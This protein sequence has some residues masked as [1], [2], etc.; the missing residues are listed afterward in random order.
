MAVRGN[1]GGISDQ[2]IEQPAN[3]ISL[4]PVYPVNMLVKNPNVDIDVSPSGLSTLAAAFK[5]K[6][7]A[8]GKELKP[9][10]KE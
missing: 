5:R 7:N 3:D 9:I 8:Q 1:N 4:R 6:K 10:L 2:D